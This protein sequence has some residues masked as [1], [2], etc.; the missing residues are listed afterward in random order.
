VPQREHI[1]NRK[2]LPTAQLLHVST[3]KMNEPQ[4]PKALAQQTIGREA[5]SPPFPGRFLPRLGSCIYG[6]AILRAMRPLRSEDPSSKSMRCAVVRRYCA[7]VGNL[8]H[9]VQHALSGMTGG[10][11]SDRSLNE[12]SVRRGPK[13]QT[14]W[15]TPKPAA[16]QQQLPSEQFCLGNSARRFDQASDLGP[17]S[18]TRTAEQRTRSVLPL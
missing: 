17:V 12:A 5:T 4:A 11:R 13:R 1:H 3:S 16:R 2:Y 6:A 14:P 9:R 15:T 7:S 18:A 10:I 8:P